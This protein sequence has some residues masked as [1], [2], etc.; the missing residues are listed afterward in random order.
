MKYLVITLLILPFFLSCK[1]KIKRTGRIQI[2]AIIYHDPNGNLYNSELIQIS[3]LYFFNHRFV[4][5]IPYYNDSATLSRFTYINIDKRKI[6][7]GNSLDELQKSSDYKDIALK[8]HGAIFRPPQVPNYEKRED[9][10]DTSFAGYNYKRLRIVNDSSYSV[11]YIH[12]TDTVLPFSLAPQIDKDYNGIL[13]RIDT[14]DKIND[15]FI[16]LRMIVSDTIPR[17]VYNLLKRKKDDEN[18]FRE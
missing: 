5:H 12:K 8:K 15:R 4:E 18:T 7:N 17:S 14:Y 1:K 9:I 16:S 6:I 2:E 3:D 13:N 11:F 10:P